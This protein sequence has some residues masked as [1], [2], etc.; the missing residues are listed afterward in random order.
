MCFGNSQI[1]E[2]K[3]DMWGVLFVLS[4]LDICANA[5]SYMRMQMLVI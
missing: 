3:M 4:F 5:Y 1:I 2:K